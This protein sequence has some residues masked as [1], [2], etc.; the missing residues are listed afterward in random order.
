MAT[1]NDNE[2]DEHFVAELQDCAKL[3]VE[4]LQNSDFTDASSLIHSLYEVRDRHVFQSVGRLTRA[5]HNA[6]V[7]FNVDSGIAR[8]E[9]QPSGSEIRD[10]SDR[11][12]Y[13]LALTQEAANKT[14]D[15]VE[16]SAPIAMNLGQ[17]AATLKAEWDKL[18]RRELNKEQFSDL[19]ERMGDFLEH[20]GTGTAQLNQNLQDIILEQGYQDLTG[21]VLKKVIELITDVE[22]ELVDL[23]RIA[24]QVEDVAGITR[25]T[26]PAKPVE[27][28]KAEGPQ[29]HAKQ[30]A[31]VVNGQD[32]VDDLLSSLGF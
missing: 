23:V 4:K 7:N 17:E 24:G 29:I 5:L 19:Y 6:I 1:T 13:V 22:K 18:R 21:Q 12:H 25:E 8:L 28:L 3:L 26:S 14:M 15:R 10:A 2:R 9:D 32:D 27:N 11:L 20:L 16:S 31:D 30:R